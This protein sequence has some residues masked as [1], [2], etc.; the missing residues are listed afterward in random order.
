M[1]FVAYW[2]DWGFDVYEEEVRYKIIIIS[3]VRCM[4]MK[5]MIEVYD[6]AEFIVAGSS[7]QVGCDRLACC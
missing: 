5:P 6:L 7:G 1:R 2:L 3:E 4:W